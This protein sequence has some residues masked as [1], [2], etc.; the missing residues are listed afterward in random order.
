MSPRGNRREDP[1]QTKIPLTPYTHLANLIDM[2]RLHKMACC[3]LRTLALAGSE[4]R[5]CC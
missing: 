3:C 1:R 5:L 4:S 2:Q